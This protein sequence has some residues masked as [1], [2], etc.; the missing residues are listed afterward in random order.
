M[1]L[2]LLVHQLRKVDTFSRQSHV[3]SQTS[4][5]YGKLQNLMRIIVESGLLYTTAPFVTFIGF[6][7]GSN[8]VYVAT[9]AVRAPTWL[10]FQGS[11]LTRKQEIQIVGISFNLIVIRT[12]ALAR[13]SD[14]FTTDMKGAGSRILPL[15]FI[16]TESSENDLERPVDILSEG[17]F[18][19]KSATV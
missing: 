18:I 7:T 8:G 3:H 1:P 4:V 16:S 14:Q 12:S 19:R 10:C 17:P 13:R 11:Y 5:S 6:V 15:Q 2:G 9:A